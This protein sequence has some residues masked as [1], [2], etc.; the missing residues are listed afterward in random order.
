MEKIEVKQY[1][2]E[3]GDKVV[4][5]GFG[6]HQVGT[7]RPNILEHCAVK[8]HGAA[9]VSPIEFLFGDRSSHSHVYNVELEDGTIERLSPSIMI[10]VADFKKCWHVVNGDGKIV[11]GGGLHITHERAEELTK[12]FPGNVVLGADIPIND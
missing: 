12:R 9:Y 4:V 3:A 5:Y 2:F 8:D 1:V 10:P 7:I 11:A 6:R